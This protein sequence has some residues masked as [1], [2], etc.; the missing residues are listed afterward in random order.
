MKELKNVF[1]KKSDFQILGISKLIAVFWAFLQCEEHGTI[2]CSLYLFKLKWFLLARQKLG[3]LKNRHGK[4]IE[5]MQLVTFLGK[6]FDR[7]V[8]I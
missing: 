7:S 8:N 6:S 4:Q 1:L 3:Q 2:P 5:K